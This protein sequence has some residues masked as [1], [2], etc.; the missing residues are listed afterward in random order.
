[1][2]IDLD[3]KGLVSLVMGIEPYYSAMEHPLAALCGRY[4]GGFHDKWVW[5]KS[6]LEGLSEEELLA[7]Y[8]VCRESW[9]NIP[10]IAVSEPSNEKVIQHEGGGWSKESVQQ[11]FEEFQDRVGEK[12]FLGGTPTMNQKP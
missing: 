5:T 9:E 1:M 2:N 6:L 11:Q 8:T 4:I 7:L 10:P 3:K 12:I